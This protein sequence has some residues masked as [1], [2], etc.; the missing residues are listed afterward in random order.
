MNFHDKCDDKS[1]TVTIILTTEG[2]LFGGFTPIAWDSGNSYKTDGSQKSF[3]F[4]VKNP[5]NIEGKIFSV[6]NPERA[7]YCHSSLGPIFS[8]YAIKIT[9]DCNMNPNSYT[10][11]SNSYANDTGI[12]GNQFC[13]G[14][15]YFTV[16][17]IEAF[18]V[19]D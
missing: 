13:T 14:S 9:N 6:K 18:A 17:E 5:H 12:A 1:N 4:S 11:L 2:F 19:T 15:S 7:I 3:T 10:N 16:K 8:N